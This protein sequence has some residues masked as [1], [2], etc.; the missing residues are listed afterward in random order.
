MYGDETTYPGWWYRL[1]YYNSST[2][3]FPAAVC[4]GGAAHLK[5]RRHSSRGR[6]L[7]YAVCAA[8]ATPESAADLAGVQVKYGNVS[9]AC[10]PLPKLGAAECTYGPAF[11]QEREADRQ[12][13]TTDTTDRHRQAGRQTGRQTDR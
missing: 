2:A 11:P 9:A 10:K 12:T 8:Q 4:A 5:A 1:Q 3:A 6:F 13:Y 7:P